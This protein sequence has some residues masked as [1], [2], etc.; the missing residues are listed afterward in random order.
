M[1]L[2][3]VDRALLNKA[4]SIICW[5][6]G[7]CSLPDSRL[8]RLF[9]S[10][11]R[12]LRIELI[13]LAWLGLYTYPWTNPHNAGRYDPLISQMPIVGWDQPYPDQIHCGRRALRPQGILGSCSYKRG[14]EG[15]GKYGCL[16]HDKRTPV[17]LCY[18][19]VLCW[20]SGSS[21]RWM[22]IKERKMFI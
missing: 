20:Q 1:D 18:C 7:L 22:D 8:A 4:N 19:N 9:Y 10:L 15:S 11:H 3:L 5:W 13:L 2:A 12:Y 16:P 21:G 6:V 17:S 14:C